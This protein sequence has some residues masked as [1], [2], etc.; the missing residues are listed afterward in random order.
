VTHNCPA[1]QEPGAFPLWGD[2]VYADR[3]VDPVT[4]LATMSAAEVVHLVC[5]AFDTGED[6]ATF[7]SSIGDHLGCFFAIGTAAGVERVPA[8]ICPDTFGLRGELFGDIVRGYGA[9]PLTLTWSG[10]CGGFPVTVDVLDAYTNVRV[11]GAAITLP[12]VPTS[13]HVVSECGTVQQ[14]GFAWGPRCDAIDT[15]GLV[16][17]RIESVACWTLGRDIDVALLDDH[18]VRVSAECGD[19]Q[20]TRWRAF[21]D[22]ITQEP[23]G[24]S[25]Q[26]VVDHEVSPGESLWLECVGG[27]PWGA[28]GT[29]LVVG[30]P[31]TGVITDVVRH[32]AVG[33]VGETLA[34]DGGFSGDVLSRPVADPEPPFDSIGVS[35]TCWSDTTPTVWLD[36]AQIFAGAT[37]SLAPVVV[38]PTDQLPRDEGEIELLARCEADGSTGL[39]S[40]PATCTRVRYVGGAP[41]A[42]GECE[43]KPVTNGGPRI[44]LVGGP[45]EFSVVAD[46]RDSRAVRFVQISPTGVVERELGWR[47][48]SLADPNVV[49]N[50]RFELP[51]G[52]T[53]EMIAAE[54]VFGG[55]IVVDAFVPESISAT[56]NCFSSELHPTPA[57]TILS[58]RPCGFVALTLPETGAHTDRL[59]AIA[60]LM[61]A[62]GAALR[63]ASRR[64]PASPCV[65]TYAVPPRMC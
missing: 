63:L 62:L 49:E 6:G 33:R 44:A 42:T 10:H 13:I 29:F 14:R 8:V 1:G 21:S 64:R 57:G 5:A 32:M 51:P 3:F 26:R 40:G 16:V 56:V 48:D 19:G 46:C 45:R 53:A 39:P 30:D 47:F 50:F 4:S 2:L 28:W 36:G 15:D 61:V 27:A 65:S 31:A 24:E 43:V 7:A 58:H 17:T 11:D 60:A 35:G 12:S 38:Q 20:I 59:A 34:G 37:P 23:W 25:G 55:H 54:C 41:V 9:T 52:V 18:T 22:V